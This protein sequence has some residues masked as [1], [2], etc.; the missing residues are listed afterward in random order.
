MC[1]LKNSI[2]IPDIL[3]E[4]YDAISTK[5]TLVCHINQPFD[6]AFESFLQYNR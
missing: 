2:Q 3:S 5:R 6:T 4:N 1:Q